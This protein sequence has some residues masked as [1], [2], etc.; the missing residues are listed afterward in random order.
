[1]NALFAPSSSA[2]TELSRDA[3]E[4]KITQLAANIN[5]ANYQFLLLVAEFDQS[6][7]WADWG[8][9]SCAHW[10]N[11][12]CGIALGAAREKVRVA[13]A[14]QGLPKIC[15]AF[16]SGELSYSKARA[17]TR[18]GHEANEDY[19]L[20]LAEH[21]SASH[22]E[23]S[24]RQLKRVSVEDAQSA[25]LARS[26][27]H[28]WDNAGNLVIK[29]V[30]PAEQGAVFLKALQM[31][32]ENSEPALDYSTTTEAGVSAETRGQQRA[33][34]LLGM[35]EHTLAGGTA[36][37][38]T[39][40][41]FQVVIHSDVSQA[42]G[43]LDKAMHCIEDG[44][45][46]TAETVERLCCDSSV[47]HMVF[48]KGEPISIGRKSRTIPP[49]MRRALQRRDRGCRFP[50]CCNSRF[51]DGHH[52]QH[53]SKGGET[54]LGNLVLLCSKHHHLVHE[55]GFS[56]RRSAGG[57]LRFARPDGRTIPEVVPPPKPLSIPLAETQPWAW[58]G[59]SM[60]FGMNLDILLGFEAKRGVSH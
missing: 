17:M 55:G 39:A 1:M 32:S 43:M 2:N 12:K 15:A 5:A 22:I 34:A 44:P 18:I 45:A 19:L 13:N 33:D 16:E 6:E 57:K 54:S 27:Q 14:L 25:Y 7:W 51:V 23:K 35:A 49:P 8:C 21:G 38:K 58:R 48:D 42:E 31:L 26:L 50:G 36:L 24:V 28:H 59:E 20:M 29:A 9:S 47:S 10:L 52:I 46:L 40:D 11:W 60:D 4:Q 41:R 30:L 56:V 3:L 37:G 53:W